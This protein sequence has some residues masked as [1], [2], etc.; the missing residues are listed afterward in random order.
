MARSA[1]IA[2][3][4]FDRTRRMSNLKSA[5]DMESPIRI[6]VPLPHMGSVNTWLLPGDPLTLVDTGPRE[7][8]A[9][10]ALEVGLARAGVRVEDIELVL[11]THHHLDHTGLATTI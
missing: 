9:L 5:Q 2:I 4:G 6:P 1:L 11:V 7:D 10:S 3:Q 8:E